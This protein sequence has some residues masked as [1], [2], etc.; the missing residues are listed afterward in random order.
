MERTQI[1]FAQKKL[2]HFYKKSEN[3]LLFLIPQKFVLLNADVQSYTR[4]WPTHEER[5][6]CISS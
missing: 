2:N 4:T 5:F 6:K 1:L 3:T